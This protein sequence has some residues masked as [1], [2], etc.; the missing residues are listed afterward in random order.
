[1]NAR[2][3][4]AQRWYRQAQTDLDVVRTLRSAGHHAAACFHSQQAAEKA[5][6]AVLFAAGARVVLEHSVRELARQCERHDSA[7]AAL[8]GDT[9]LLDQ[10]YIPTRYPNG[11]PSPAVPGEA[12]T[13]TQAA[14]AQD[15]ANRVLAAAGA[16]LGAQAGGTTWE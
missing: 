4:E 6:K 13:E 3:V 16:F 10:F 5:L 2:Q 15:A 1:M 12:Y 8:A 7:F 9:A 11:L 14:T